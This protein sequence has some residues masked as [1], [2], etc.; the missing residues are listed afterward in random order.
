MPAKS[1]DQLKLIYSIRNKYKSKSRTPKK[2][3]WVWDGE[4]SHTENHI[5]RFSEYVFESVSPKIEKLPENAISSKILTHLANL[6]RFEVN[7][8]P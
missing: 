6:R 2:W 3:D 7:I 1:K 8:V 4:W 5:E